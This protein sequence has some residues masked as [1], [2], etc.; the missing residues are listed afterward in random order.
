MPI[1]DRY[2]HDLVLRRA[3]D[4]APD[5]THHVEPEFL[6]ENY[7]PFR[8]NWQDRTGIEVNGPELGGTIIANVLVFAPRSLQPTE[9]D[10]IT[11]EDRLAD[12]LF[13]KD[14]QFGSIN[15]HLEIHAREISSG[16]AGPGS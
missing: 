8:G 1:A 3:T 13:V 10:Q 6:P 7:V 4:S 11:R 5:R 12:I 9:R 16:E 2:I 15:D 14:L